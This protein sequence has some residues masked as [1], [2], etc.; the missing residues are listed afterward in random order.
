LHQKVTMQHSE[1]PSSDL[2]DPG[3]RRF[4]RGGLV[5]PVVL[6][7]LISKPVLGQTIPYV[8]TV[9][10][11]MSGNVSAPRDLNANCAIGQ[12]TAYWI[13]SDPYTVNN[14][15]PGNLDRGNLKKNQP[16]QKADSGTLFS[17]TTSIATSTTTTGLFA[18]TSTSSTSSSSS[19]AGTFMTGDGKD[20]AT[21]LQVLMKVTSNTTN[22]ELGQIAMT[23]LLN[24][25]AQPAR[26]PVSAS[27]VVAMFNAVQNGGTYVVNGYDGWNKDKVMTYLRKLYV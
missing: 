17:G 12:S 11:Q 15:W 18:Q 1:L 22:G 5:A 23:S 8:C 14:F 2:P 6:G 25:L 19:F 4:T 7:S 21:M 13:G 20:A 9:S 26:Y 27:Q 10:G 16:D 24:A 3:R